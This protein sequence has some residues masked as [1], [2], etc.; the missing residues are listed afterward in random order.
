MIKVREGSNLGRDVVAKMKRSEW[1]F[2]ENMN[3]R[4]VGFGDGL[5]RR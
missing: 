2:K 4:W 3:E 1:F 5:D